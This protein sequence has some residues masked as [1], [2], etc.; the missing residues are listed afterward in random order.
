MTRRSTAARLAGGALSLI[1]LTL[2]AG[3]HNRSQDAN[4]ENF[5]AAINDFLGQR[6]HLCL[7]KYDWPV[8]TTT[9]DRASGARDAVQMPVLEKLGLV[10][11]NDMM[12][13]RVDAD[14]KKI[15]A[16]ARQY[17]LTSEGQ[18]Y[19]LHIPEVVATGTSHVTHPADLCAAT[20]T[21]DK[22]VGWERPMQLDGKTVTSVV[23][24]YKVEPAA[25]AKDPDAQRV[26][27]MV[28]RVIEGAGTMQLRE[29]VH[30]TSNG[31]VADEIF[32]R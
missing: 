11:G 31:W 2:I 20:L 22:V 1:A 17:Q 19:Y 10:K 4:Q 28:K 23:Y 5:T 6:G 16:A 25:W 15:T 13:E 8:Y 9:D 12:V 14:G 3:C 18:K 32:Q 26:F 27:P 29:G 7:A 30:L 24:T 21:L